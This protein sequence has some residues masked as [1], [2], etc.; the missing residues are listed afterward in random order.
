[1]TSPVIRT[2]TEEVTF[3]TEF[4]DFV[5]GADYRLGVG[6]AGSKLTAKLEL[7]KNEVAVEKAPASFV[8]GF[9]SSWWDVD[10]VSV[11]GFVLSRAELPGKGEKLRLRVSLSR[12]HANTLKKIYVLVARKYGASRW[13]IED[14]VEMDDSL[15]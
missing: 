3:S 9:A 2:S 4:S 11:Q 8:Q 13:Y 5:P 12:A 7:L 1:M 15:W 14:G 6:T 10:R